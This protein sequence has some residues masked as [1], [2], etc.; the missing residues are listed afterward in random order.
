MTLMDSTKDFKTALRSVNT[1]L[2]ALNDPKTS[3]IKTEKHLQ[4]AIMLL[5]AYTYQKEFYSD[6]IASEKCCEVCRKKIT[7]KKIKQLK[8]LL[9]K[10]EEA[11]K[12]ITEC[13]EDYQKGDNVFHK[14]E[15][16]KRDWT[17]IKVGELI[18]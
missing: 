11:I 16:K 8:T 6:M 14:D 1:M 10:V 4:D 15:K 2:E 13:I 12:R 5:T 17:K 9:S 18:Q 3:K 7:P